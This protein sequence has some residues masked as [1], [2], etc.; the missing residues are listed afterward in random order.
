MPVNIADIQG[1]G[2]PHVRADLISD[3][4]GVEGQLLRSEVVTCL[5]LAII[6]LRRARF[7]RHMNA[8]VCGLLYSPPESLMVHLLIHIP[9]PPVLLRGATACAGDRGLV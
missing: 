2:F 3:Y 4:D 9:G 5:R 1:D 6:Q 8:P 7:M